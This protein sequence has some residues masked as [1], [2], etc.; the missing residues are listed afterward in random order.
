MSETVGIRELRQNL[1]RYLRRVVAGERLVVTERR[2]PV[3]V[4]APWVDEEDALERLIGD[5]RATRGRGNLIE[6]EPFA[7]PVS[8]AGT[9]ALEDERSERLG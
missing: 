1:S 9:R 2:R 6:V 5:G 3:A 4:L 8:D 7:R